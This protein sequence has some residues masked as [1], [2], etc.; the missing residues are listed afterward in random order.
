V[1]G[2]L[3]RGRH[4]LTLLALAAHGKQTVIGRTTIAVS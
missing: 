3:R 2:Q 1:F 4:K